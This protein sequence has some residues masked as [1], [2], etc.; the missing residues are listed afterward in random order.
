V[1]DG[2]EFA[3]PNGS[4]KLDILLANGSKLIYGATDLLFVSDMNSVVLKDADRI[5]VSG[6][7]KSCIVNAKCLR[8]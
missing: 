5:V 1:R 3:F 4:G 7:D 8:H 6:R 2:T